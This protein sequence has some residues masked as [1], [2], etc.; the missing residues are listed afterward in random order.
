VEVLVNKP[1]STEIVTVTSG[2][3]LLLCRES[4]AA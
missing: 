1:G 2:A 3:I 4:K